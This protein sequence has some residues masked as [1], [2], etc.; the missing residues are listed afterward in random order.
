MLRTM[1]AGI[2]VI[3][4]GSTMGLAKQNTPESVKSL[5]GLKAVYVVVDYNAPPEQQYGLTEDQLLSQVKV[6]LNADNIRVL[7]R[8]E[9]LETPGSPYLRVNIEGAVLDPKRADTDFMY[10][11]TVELVQQVKLA[12]EQRVQ[13]EGVTWSEGSFAVVPHD[14][15]DGI[16]DNLED[17]LLKFNHALQ[18]ANQKS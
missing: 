13:S 2:L 6:T 3:G 16:K 4:L 5:R 18:A 14:R 15:L 17:L 9:W 10:N 8:E 7:D 11:Y 1:L 12:R